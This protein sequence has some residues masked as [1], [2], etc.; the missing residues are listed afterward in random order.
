VRSLA[1]AALLAASARASAPPSEAALEA[2]V[3]DRMSLPGVDGPQ[4]EVSPRVAKM[5]GKA[6]LEALRDPRDA[7]HIE[8]VLALYARLDQSGRPA[9]VKYSWAPVADAAAALDYLYVDG[10]PAAYRRW[11]VSKLFAGACAGTRDRITLDPG[12]AAVDRWWSRCDKLRVRGR[13]DGDARMTEYFE[14]WEEDPEAPR[15]RDAKL[16]ATAARDLMLMKRPDTKPLFER[17]WRLQKSIEDAQSSVM[18]RMMASLDANTALSAER[19]ARLEAIERSTFD[20]RMLVLWANM[21]PKII[22]EGFDAAE[23][24]AY[25]F[26]PAAVRLGWPQVPPR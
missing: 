12:D 6:L 2:L 13:R 16:A 5:K 9:G 7:R 19:R 1:L 21:T 23:A 26:E 20:H 17:V 4:V 15:W 10:A 8:L 22:A 18:G 11:A 3:P 24:K 14:R 25:G